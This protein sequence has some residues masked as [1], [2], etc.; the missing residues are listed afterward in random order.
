MQLCSI[1]FCATFEIKIPCNVLKDINSI[2]MVEKISTVS[3]AFSRVLV[4]H[5]MPYRIWV[6]SAVT[7]PYL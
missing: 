4:N 3:V 6:R 7:E 5:Q 2:R 1:I